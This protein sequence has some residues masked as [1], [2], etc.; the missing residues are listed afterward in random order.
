MSE[1]PV[2]TGPDEV[3]APSAIIEI[4]PTATGSGPVASS[5]G[6]WLV[7][8]ALGS[9]QNFSFGGKTWEISLRRARY[10]KPYTVTLKKFTHEVYPGT[11]T[12]KNFASTIAL[13]DPQANV[14][15]EVLIYMN[16]P[17]RYKGDTYYQSGMDDNGSVSI[18]QVMHNPSFFAPYVGCVIVG[19][20]L[21]I[22]FSFHLVKFGRRRRAMQPA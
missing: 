6:T 9:S 2:T 4:L 1:S 7:S 14:N 13:S 3:N 10:Y 11:Q 16:H 22:Q 20:G 19:A 21:L 15:R 8:E 12:P 18:L 5:L 17:L